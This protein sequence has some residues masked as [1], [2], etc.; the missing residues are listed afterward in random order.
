MKNK[1]IL[2]VLSFIAVI[3]QASAQ[4][5]NGMNYQAIVR[6]AGGSPADNTPVALRF[7]IHDTAANGT[8][9]FT[10]TI[11]VVT[12][13]FGLVTTVIGGNT[14]LSAV[15][16]GSGAK[17][18]Q[19]EVDINNSGTFVDMGTSQLLS[20]PYA[21]YAANSQP[22][23][24]GATGANGATWY[25][26]K[27]IP[28]TA[29]GNVN[30]LYIDSVTD[31]YY[32]KTG[33]STW[34]AQHSL[35]GS[36]GINGTD[37]ATGPTGAAGANGINGTNG[38]DG[39]TGATGATGPAGINGIDGATGAAG[40]NGT[41][42]LD[43]V[44]GA[45]GPAGLNGAD[46]ATGAAGTN[47]TNGVD[48]A[49]GAT[50]PAGLNGADGATGATGTNGTNGVDGATGATGPAG[51]NGADGATG[52]AGT[53]GTNGVDGATGATGPAG[54][55]GA[56]GATGAAGTNGTNG[57]D[58]ATGATGPAGINGADGATGAA[59]TNGTNGIDG[60]TGATGPA[61]INGTD[62]VT[63]PTGAT[64]AGNLSSSSTTA[65]IATGAQTFTVQAGLPYLSGDRVRML[66][67][68]SNFMEGNV[69]SYAGVT[70]AISV[71]TAQGNGTF[72]TWNISS[73]GN[74]GPTGP[75]GLL[76]SGSSTGIMP[77]WDG[78][79]WVVNKTNFYNNGG[80]VGINTANPPSLFTVGS[81]SQFQVDSIGNIAK[82]NNVD[83][84][85]PTQ[86]GNTQSVMF[87][88]GAGNLVWGDSVNVS[89]GSM[90]GHVR[91]VSSANATIDYSDFF[92]LVN[93]SVN[94]IVTLPVPVAN[95]EGRMIICRNATS[96][97]KTITFTTSSGSFI[98]GQGQ[99]NRASSVTCNSNNIGEQNIRFICAGG[100]WYAW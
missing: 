17:Y 30:D 2:I 36:A 37:G 58:G 79:T 68:S 49:T 3:S 57:V 96:P 23:P 78:S 32:V 43:G 41:N 73:V 7:T 21:L 54:I 52:A 55:N 66:A 81:S 63:G 89:G 82:I 90:T 75:A 74:P 29:L 93:S 84:S 61:G 85:W 9:V 50:G 33:S 35:K 6:G 98:V 92:V 59:G 67:N 5:A 24:A 53:N 25:L 47:G 10:E 71:D 31:V 77:Y 40:I 28:Q 76:P 8:A 15:N 64:G 12:N 4:A 48:G 27:G 1:L 44:T 39:A 34:L 42:G 22:G 62:G 46:G 20:V 100:L 70:L 86:Q 97:T 94:T 18:L 95:L 87:N 91:V 11:N 16:W 14:G 60:A 45:T 99:N 19:V 69:T 13:Q 88:D 72:S 65:T 26:G 51:L 38:V 56:D 83:Y 80:N